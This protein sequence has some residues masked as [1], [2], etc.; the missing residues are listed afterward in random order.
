MG[1]CIFGYECVCMCD[2]CFMYV[3]THVYVGD[4]SCAE[5]R[6]RHWSVPLYHALYNFLET[7]FLIEPETC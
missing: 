2:V 6:G 5:A 4:L 1:V 7:G 3:C